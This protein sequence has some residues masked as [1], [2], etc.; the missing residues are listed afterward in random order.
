[1]MFNYL[2]DF[3]KLK[4]KLIIV[5]IVLVILIFFSIA[6]FFI[7]LSVSNSV[8]DLSESF[9]EF[10]AIP[11]PEKP[12]FIPFIGPVKVVAD[13]NCPTVLTLKLFQMIEDHGVKLSNE[14]KIQFV[15]QILITAKKYELDP[16]LFGAMIARESN[17][18]VDAVSSANALGPGQVVPKWHQEKLKA[19]GI[20]A[21]NL[22]SIK[23]GVDVAGEIV[24]EYLN[25][26]NDDYVFAFSSYVGSGGYR[27]DYIESI[28]NIYN[29]THR[30][31]EE[32][33]LYFVCSKI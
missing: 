14:T 20:K 24:R 7:L 6:T 12:L 11:K 27:L 10:Q 9:K 29:E 18:N 26:N 33:N 31:F 2:N 16:I 13:N 22:K 21:E 30:K 19:R 28:F 32:S 8:N 17:F 5:F 1:M 4:K 15:N 23:Y 3:Y 25:L